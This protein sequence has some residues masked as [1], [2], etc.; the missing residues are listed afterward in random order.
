MGRWWWWWW[1]SRPSSEFADGSGILHVCV[2]TERN[3]I[4]ETYHRSAAHEPDFHH[5]D[6]TVASACYFPLRSCCLLMSSRLVSSRLAST[7]LVPRQH[8]ER[9]IACHPTTQDAASSKN[10]ASKTLILTITQCKPPHSSANPPSPFNVPDPMRDRVRRLSSTTF[11]ARLRA[12]AECVRVLIVPDP[13][14]TALR[15]RLSTVAWRC[16]WDYIGSETGI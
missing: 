4:N 5:R 1:W 9:A 8:R 11:L 14:K 12:L 3:S 7:Q 15:I 10:A 6:E 13:C 2:Y 16:K